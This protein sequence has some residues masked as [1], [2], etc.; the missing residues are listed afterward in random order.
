M[1]VVRER[2]RVK[3]VELPY[4]LPRSLHDS[5]AAEV[6][7]TMNM[8]PNSRSFPLS[9]KS[10]VKGEQTNVQADLAPPFG[11]AVLCPVGSAIHSTEQKQEMGVVMGAMDGTRAG[12]KVYLMNQ[13]LPVVRRA[14]KPMPMVQTIIN[15]M[16]EYASVTTKMMTMTKTVEQILSITPRPLVKINIL[17]KLKTSIVVKV[18]R[19]R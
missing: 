3:L 10:I 5:L 11:S 18:S 8:L 1:R 2:M 7:R 13:R 15:H 16:N 17:G 6:V 14:L 9:P 4:A 19:T 12:V